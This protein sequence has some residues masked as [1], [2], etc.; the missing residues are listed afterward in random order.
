LYNFIHTFI[1]PYALH[2]YI[3]YL[4]NRTSSVNIF[5]DGNVF[6]NA[7]IDHSLINM[8]FLVVGEKMVTALKALGPEAALAAR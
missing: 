3:A 4:K 2:S 5:Y 7:G 8:A 1:P 6:S